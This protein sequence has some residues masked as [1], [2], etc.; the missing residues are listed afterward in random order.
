MFNKLYDNLI[1]FYSLLDSL[2][3]QYVKMIFL[4]RDYS[5]TFSSNTAI[6]IIAGGENVFLKY[7]EERIRN[8]IF[9]LL[10]LIFA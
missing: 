10:L 9:I 5:K 8:L 3:N 4:S 2:S 1:K 7:I 6:I